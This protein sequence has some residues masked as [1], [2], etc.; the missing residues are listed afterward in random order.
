MFCS[1][2]ILKWKLE[3]LKDHSKSKFSSSSSLSYPSVTSVSLTLLSIFSSY[4]IS[5]A[6][7]AP[8]LMACG[9]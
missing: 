2:Y 8:S 9:T 5:P 6:S 4:D 1:P 3:F 7:P